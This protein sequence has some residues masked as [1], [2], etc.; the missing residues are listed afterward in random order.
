M[1]LTRSGKIL[2]VAN[3]SRNTV[4]VFDAPTGRTLEVIS[5]ALYPEAPPGST[6]N[7][8]ALS[9]DEHTLFIANADN[10][11]VAVF[12]VS[13]PGKSRSLG[14]IPTGWYPTSVRVSPMARN[15]SLP[16]AKVWC[17]CPIPWRPARNQSICHGHPAI[18][19]ATLQGFAQCDRFARA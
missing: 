17:R 14:F 3:A 8:L 15:S 6:P 7:S 13:N 16:M 1:A 18:H 19:R 5:S 12:D 11:T 4:T 10:N 2:F 9:P